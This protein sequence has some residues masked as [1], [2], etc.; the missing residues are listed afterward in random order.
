MD[1]EE[2]AEM[3]ATMEELGFLV[4]W[5]FGIGRERERRV[6]VPPSP[7]EGFEA[8]RLAEPGIATTIVFSARVI[9]G[10][11]NR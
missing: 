6:V 9:G 5:R 1:G 2:E 4:T 8:V 3:E 11:G 10:E 7:R